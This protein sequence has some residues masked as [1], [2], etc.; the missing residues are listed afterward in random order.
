MKIF[1]ILI[2]LTLIT[3]LTQAQEITVSA[4]AEIIAGVELARK[5]ALQKA[6]V[7]SVRQAAGNFIRKS[8]LVENSKLISSRIYSQAEG[9]ISNYQILSQSAAAG[10]YKL[11]IKAEVTSKLFSDLEE[12]KL[13]IENQ[14]NNPRLLLFVEDVQ[15]TALAGSNSNEFQLYVREIEDSLTEQ[16]GINK[17]SDQIQRNL[18][19]NLKGLG[20][21]LAKQSSELD[22][23]Q[24]V[25]GLQGWEQN[26]SQLVDSFQFPFELLI[27]GQSELK[28]LGEKDFGFGLLKIAGVKSSFLVYSAQTGEELKKIT[29]TEKAYARSTQKALDLAIEKAGRAGAENLAQALLPLVDLN[30]GQ[31]NLKLK[32]NNLAAYEDLTKLEKVIKKLSGVQNFK[33]YS[34]ADDSASY[35]L[36]V[37]Q[38]T[39]VLAERF[40]NE[41][42]F[43]LQV[44]KLGPDYLELQAN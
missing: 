28:Q 14:T 31:K 25:G 11:E 38:T 26:S 41:K 7:K 19:L 35:L 21:R 3:P 37:L 12:L 32:V 34:F 36:K 30:S 42:E 27:I 18:S 13:I 40:A 22:F 6:M 9:Y 16:A 20:F 4:E 29:F 44:K 2:L 8:I 43:P 24:V 17:I 23:L 10:V 39:A 33:L 5:E 1:I 15:T